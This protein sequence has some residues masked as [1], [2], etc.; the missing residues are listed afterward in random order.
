ML[1]VFSRLRDNFVEAQTTEAVALFQAAVDPTRYPS[2]T[3]LVEIGENLVRSTKI[4]GGT[5]ISGAGEVRANFGETPTLSWMD[6]RLSG[7]TAR[8]NTDTAVLDVFMPPED[9]KIPYGVILRVDVGEDWGHLIEQMFDRALLS[10]FVALTLTVVTILIVA[11]EVVRPLATIRKTVDEALNSPETTDGWHTGISR[12]DEIGELA[13]TVDQL[14]FLTSS[15]INDELAAS[16]AIIERAP[17]GILVFSEQ[18]HIVSANAA[19]LDLFG[20]ASVETLLRRDLRSLFRY[21]GETVDAAEFVA[22]GAALGNGEILRGSDDAFPC[23]VAGNTVKGLDGSVLRRFLIFVDMRALVNEVRN[24]MSRRETAEADAA[25]LRD[26]LRLLRRM[27]DAC[28]VLTELSSADIAP[29]RTVT[30]IP[31]EQI[32]G[33][34]TRLA[35]GG[36]PPIEQVATVDLPPILGDPAQMRKLFDTALETVRLRSAQAQPDI[37]VTAALNDGGVATFTVKEGEAGSNA[38]AISSDTDVA[39]LLA[40]LGV[41]CRHQAGMLLSTSGIEE[42]NAISFRLKVDQT[43]LEFSRANN[44]KAA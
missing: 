40:A 25:Q 19:V 29:S 27:F 43:S 22:R 10:L 34:R 41:L 38:P 44:S 30:V 31:E 24:E 42:A 37:C 39:L 7:N 3:R 18:G 4:A 26:E 20:E 36:D 9:T 15:T 8:L 6:A 13:R 1:P 33:W 32:E 11:R 35:K 23:L 14:L 21:N 16:H 5:L 12:N 2:V 28:L 17:H